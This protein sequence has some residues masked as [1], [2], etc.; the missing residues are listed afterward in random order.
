M[1]EP[2]TEAEHEALAALGYSEAWLEAGLLDRA[3][4][5]EQFERLQ[6][7][8]TRK[9]GKYRAQALASWLAATGPI[10]DAQIDACLVLT[11]A[12][13][14]AKGVAGAVA[15]L[16]QSP[17]ITLEQLE[18]IAR[19]DPKQVRRHEALIRRTFLS[20]RL[21]QEVSDEIIEQ[22]VQSKDAAIQTKLVR[23]SRLSR[24]HAEALAKRGAN[25]TI[26]ANAQAWFQDKKSWKG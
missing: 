2:V 4:L 11:A 17:R 26:R 19:S 5:A 7:G 16:I 12:D 25:P 20:R 1:S 10:E 21:E 8:G 6:E 23:D 9:T 15:E 24:K 13:P 18:R 3:L 14:D 22:V